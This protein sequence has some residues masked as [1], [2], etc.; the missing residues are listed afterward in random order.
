MTDNPN[1][2]IRALF[3]SLDE[4]TAEAVVTDLISSALFQRDLDMFGPLDTGRTSKTLEAL[5]QKYEKMGVFDPDIDTIAELK[6][7][8]G[9][10]AY[11][12]RE[13]ALKTLL[14]E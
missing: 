2:D 11:E 4:A 5:W 7:A 13:A 3:E 9:L 8:I 1:A 6:E 10:L 12:T 14:G